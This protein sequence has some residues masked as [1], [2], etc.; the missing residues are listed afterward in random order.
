[1]ADINSLDLATMIKTAAEEV[2]ETMLSMSVAVE[3][4]IEKVNVDGHRYVGTVS[5]A[6]SVQGNLNLHV[7]QEFAK[8]ITAEMLGS[9]PDEV[10][11]DELEDVIGE[12][13]NMIGGNVKSR[14][15]DESFTCQLSIPSI[16]S[17]SDFKIES[18][19]WMRHEVLAVSF[20]VHRAFVEMFVKS[21]N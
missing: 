1:M 14:L 16:T 15:C 4:G 10:E 9:E 6:G 7:G 2:F 18:V 21:E 5:V 12:L 20:S 13:S 11:T 17:G 3:N 19:G 8:M